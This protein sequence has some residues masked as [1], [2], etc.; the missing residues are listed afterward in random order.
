MHGIS[1]DMPVLSLWDLGM[2][3]DKRIEVIMM[4]IG[5]YGIPRDMPVS[6]L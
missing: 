4:C 6:S 1:E 5:L 2:G 3:K